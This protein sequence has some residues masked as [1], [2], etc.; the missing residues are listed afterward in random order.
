MEKSQYNKG[1]LTENWKEVF[2]GKPSEK[3]VKWL[4]KTIT[5]FSTDVKM[6]K[7]IIIT[8]H[9][10]ISAILKKPWEHDMIKS[11]QQQ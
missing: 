10:V 1:V 7:S 8:N 2:K 4:G 3:E 9:I 5:M 6:R 11:Q